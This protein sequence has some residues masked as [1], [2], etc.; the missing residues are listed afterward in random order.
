MILTSKNGKYFL[1][2]R[3]AEIGNA[4]SKTASDK[5]PI[6]LGWTLSKIADEASN[7]SGQQYLCNDCQC[8]G[9]ENEFPNGR[10]PKCRGKNISPV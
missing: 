8:I 9:F 7:A 3:V 2:G 10:C 6:D 4:L 5:E 1:T